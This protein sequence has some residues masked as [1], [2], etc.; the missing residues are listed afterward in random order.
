MIKPVAQ[1]GSP[2][3]KYMDSFIREKINDIDV[4]ASRSLL[5]ENERLYA[6][7]DMSGFWIFKSLNLVKISRQKME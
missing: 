4:F 7:L 6:S 2:E 3:E 5:E 1:A